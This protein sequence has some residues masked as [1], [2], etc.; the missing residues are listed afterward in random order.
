MF[1]IARFAKNQAERVFAVFG[2]YDDLSN[3][4]RRWVHAELHMWMHFI[5]I[6]PIFIR[7]MTPTVRVQVF[8]KVFMAASE[9]GRKAFHFLHFRQIEQT[10]LSF[11]IHRY[12]IRVS[13]EHIIQENI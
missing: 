3:P 6:A 5:L 13:Y 4:F 1:K 9:K 10:H 7:T 12:E 2:S 8:P 11:F